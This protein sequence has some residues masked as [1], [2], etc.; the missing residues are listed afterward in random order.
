[1]IGIINDE[2][3]KL[4]RQIDSLKSQNNELNAAFTEKEK[5]LKESTQN[6]I[7]SL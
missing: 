2:N 1:L 4:M 5:K 3:G 7:S 6:E